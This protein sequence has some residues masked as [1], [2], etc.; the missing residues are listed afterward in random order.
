MFEQKR[1]GLWSGM[2]KNYIEVRYRSDDDLRGKK[3]SVR[4]VGY[5]R[6]NEYIKAEK[7]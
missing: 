6:E 7:K 3:L 5:D 2:T 1:N 4:L